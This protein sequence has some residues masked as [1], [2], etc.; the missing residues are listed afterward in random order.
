MKNPWKNLP[1]NS[2]FVLKNDKKE[3]LQYNINAI[4]DHKIN[5]ETPPDPYIGDVFN[6]KIV[7]L[8]L[9]PGS[10][11][12]PGFLKPNEILERKVFP[13]L[14]KD[15]I[16]NLLHEYGKFPFYHLNPEYKL[17]G[18]FRYWSKLFSPLINREDDYKKI[19]K[20]ICCIEFFPY[21][22]KKFRPFNKILESQKY[23]FYLLEQAIERKAMIVLLRGERKWL[24]AVEKLKKNYFKPRNTR[25]PILSKRNFSDQQF[26]KILSLLNE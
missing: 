3:I 5:L 24:N 25:N 19:S 8:Q 26:E 2:P 6:A 9:N 22:S 1:N 20:N 21:H 23:S 4:S 10:D 12:P 16:K 7:L 18:G 11:F 13:K 14:N 15:N 17:T